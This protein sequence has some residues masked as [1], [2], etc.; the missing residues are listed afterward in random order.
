[1]AL[2][3]GVA[4]LIL[5][6]PGL[7]QAAEALTGFADATGLDGGAALILRATGVS[8]IA[9]FAACLCEDAGEKALAGK[10]ELAA[11]VTLFAMAAPLL[12]ELLTLVT[13]AL[14]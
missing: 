7:R 3:A 14:T 11:R 5:L 12:S 8:L 6:L 9:E 1:M 4:A 13:E 2:A 10:V